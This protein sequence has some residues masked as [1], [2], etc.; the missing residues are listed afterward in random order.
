MR[1]T[2]EFT[3][4]P[5]RLAVFVLALALV[6]LGLAMLVTTLAR[7]GGPLAAGVVL[8]VVFMA[9]GGARIYLLR[10]RARG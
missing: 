3:L 2:L 8:G 1:S 6:L 4:A 10:G 9:A 7:G 5:Y